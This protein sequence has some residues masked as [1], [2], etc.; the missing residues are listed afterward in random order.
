M[1]HTVDRH[2]AE[3]GLNVLRE[4]ERYTELYLINGYDIRPYK[5]LLSMQNYL[6]GVNGK[7][8]ELYNCS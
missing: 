1:K 6:F 2:L 8:Y 7:V 3:G 4:G 5:K